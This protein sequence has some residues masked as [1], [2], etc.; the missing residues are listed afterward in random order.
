MDPIIVWDNV[1]LQIDPWVTRY[2]ARFGI[3]TIQC[4]KRTPL[5]NAIEE[6]FPQSKKFVR[7]WRRF[8]PQFTHAELWRLGFKQISPA[9]CENYFRSV[10]V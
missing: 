9:Q 2:L 6:S 5:Y 8:Y 10:G 4:P 1:N 7:R 3:R